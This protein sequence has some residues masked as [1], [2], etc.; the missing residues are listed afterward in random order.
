M[1]QSGSSP[2]ISPVDRQFVSLG[3]VLQYL[4]EVEDIDGAIAATLDYLR[5]GF[6]YKLLWIATY[7]RENHRLMGRG[8]VTPAGEIK[9]LKERMALQP[10]DLMDQVILQRKPVPI[11]DLRQEKRSGEWQKAAQKFEVQG[12]IVFPIY[13]GETSYGLALLG[14]HLWNVV[15]RTDEK[16]RLAMVFGTLGQTLQRVEQHWQQQQTKR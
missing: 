14:S 6:E 12:S 10:G 2:N 7:D 15:P 16:A 4:R 3:R 13:H 1:S 11:A 5:T 8:G 9:F